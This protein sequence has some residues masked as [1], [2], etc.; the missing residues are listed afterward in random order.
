MSRN[1][2]LRL[3]LRRTIVCVCL[4]LILAAL[5]LGIDRCVRLLRSGAGAASR[6][7]SSA[8]P[9]SVRPLS[10]A[11]AFR[12]SSAAPPSSAGIRKPDPGGPPKPP[13]WF[14]DAAL[15][16]DSRTE[17]LQNYDGLGN[18]AY[19]AVK[20]L[21]VDTVYTKAAVRVDGKKRTVMD[22][23][24]RKKFGKIYIMLGINELGWSSSQTFLDDYAKLVD[25]L[26]KDQPGARIYLQSILP[27]ADRKSVSGA[28]ESNRKIQSYNRAIQKLA[29][30]KKVRYLAVDS[31]IAD[32]SGALPADASADGVHL[33]AR[34]CKIWCDYLKTHTD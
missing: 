8:A 27:V 30:Q 11:P 23:V 33:N 20:G 1:R 17:G 14:D 3:L 2:K 22:A 21:M 34:Y 32:T 10:S 5:G 19:F 9:S 18:A 26:R 13:G 25:D 16:G 29:K 7:A 28:A 24:K 4:G 6:P 12:V 31:A 15:I